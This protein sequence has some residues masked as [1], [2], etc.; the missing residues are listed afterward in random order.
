MDPHYNTRAMAEEVLAAR[1]PNCCDATQMSED[2]VRLLTP[3][4]G[5]MGINYERLKEMGMDFYKHKLE[6]I[7]QVNYAL[8]GIDAGLD[9]QS[10]VKGIFAAGRARNLEPGVYLGGWA[11]SGTATSGTIAGENAARMALSLTDQPRI[12]PALI[13]KIKEDVFAS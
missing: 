3:T 4:G 5:W 1:G 10:S 11:I 7:P 9:G 2:N 12:D 6:W 8:G 13:A